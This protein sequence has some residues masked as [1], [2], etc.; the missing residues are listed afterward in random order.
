MIDFCRMAGENTTEW[1]IYIE[2]RNDIMM[3]NSKKNTIRVCLLGLGRTGKEVAGA[4]LDQ[5]DVQLVAAFVRPGSEKCGQDVGTLIGRGEV[6]MAVQG[7]DQLDAFLSANEVD[8]AV[9]FSRPEATLHSA[10]ILARRQVGMVVCTTGFNDIQMQKLKTIGER[11]GSGLVY[12][13]NITLGVN[14]LMLLSNLAAS[15]LESYDCTIVDSH[16]KGKADAPSGTAKKLATQIQQS[17]AEL[18]KGREQAEVITESIRAGGIIGKH[19][20]MIAGEYDM[21]EIK[22]ES[23]SRKA[24]ATGALRA[25]RFINGRKGYHEMQE[26]LDMQRVMENYLRRHVADSSLRTPADPATASYPS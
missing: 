23:F 17:R 2:E 14:V 15:I 26:V 11:S 9:D 7:I 20:V 21:I 24:F 16:F 13:P 10:N 22:H 4:L 25:V 1:E 12:A 3:N 6:G 19:D 8:V 18:K 5:E